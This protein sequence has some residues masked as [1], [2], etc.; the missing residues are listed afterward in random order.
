MDSL[1]NQLPKIEGSFTQVMKEKLNLNTKNQ[2]NNRCNKDGGIPLCSLT[3]RL[4][5]HGIIKKERPWALY[6]SFD[7]LC[8]PIDFGDLNNG[9]GLLKINNIRFGINYLSLHNNELQ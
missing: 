1:P 4:L 8:N 9:T 7:S 2:N 5:K 6:C 3:C